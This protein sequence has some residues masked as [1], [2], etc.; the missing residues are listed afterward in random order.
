VDLLV[1]TDRP[2]SKRQQAV[3][4]DLALADIGVAKDVVVIGVRPTVA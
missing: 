3:E 1:V 4:I 2:G